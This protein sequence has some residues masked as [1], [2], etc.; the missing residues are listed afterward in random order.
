MKRRDLS[1][2]DGI[3]Q[4]L[5]HSNLIDR[6]EMWGDRERRKERDEVEL[7]ILVETKRQ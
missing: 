4:E 1:Q 5:R 2:Y 6:K 3:K 7:R